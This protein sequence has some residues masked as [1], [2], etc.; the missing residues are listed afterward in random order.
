MEE[1]FPDFI[2]GL[3]VK[4]DLSGLVLSSHQAC[5]EYKQDEL[6]VLEGKDVG[7]DQLS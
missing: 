1:I 3:V 4:L 2:G 5:E 6:V 7:Y